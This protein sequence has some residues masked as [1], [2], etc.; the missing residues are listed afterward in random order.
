MNDDRVGG[1]YPGN[2]PQQQEPEGLGTQSLA[3][4]KVLL[5][6]P[7]RRSRSV[8]MSPAGLAGR[9]D[10][11]TRLVSVGVAVRSQAH[12]LR[13]AA[14]DVGHRQGQCGDEQP[15]DKHRGPPVQKDD[16][17]V[18]QGNHNGSAAGK[19]CHQG[20]QGQGLAP[21]E[22]LVHRRHQGLTQPGGLAHRHH[23][24]EQQH[25]LPVFLGKGEEHQ[26]DAGGE[27]AEENHGTGAEFVHQPA[28]QGRAQ[29]AL[30]PGQ[31][32]NQGHGGVGDAQVAANRLEEAGK[33]G[34]NGAV[35]EHPLQT[36]HGHYAPAIKKAAL[37]LPGCGHIVCVAG[38]NF[39]SCTG[40]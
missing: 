13:P 11:P 10:C 20:G 26:A 9:R 5:A 32:E 35:A 18:Q 3:H 33:A 16:A 34:G 12:I 4:R 31:A 25:Q 24:H 23:A 37:P 2:Y 40:V 28:H 27:A 36:G 7:G 15:D 22:P 6:A 21:H 29:P 1:R 38:G 30:G 17:Q 8:V 39:G 19:G 14:N